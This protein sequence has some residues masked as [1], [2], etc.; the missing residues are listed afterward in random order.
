MADEKENAFKIS[1]I[2]YFRSG[3]CRLTV[4]AV[5][6]DQVTV[7]W[8]TYHSQEYKQITLPASSLVAHPPEKAGWQPVPLPVPQPTEPRN[9]AYD[10]RELAPRF[11]RARLN[12]LSDFGNADPGQETPF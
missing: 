3:S 1:D 9:P 6:N 11:P 4:L 8:F 7:G 10:T 5:A 2:V 12:D